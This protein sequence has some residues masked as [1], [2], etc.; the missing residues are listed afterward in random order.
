M[1]SGLRVIGSR[2]NSHWNSLAKEGRSSLPQDIV[3]KKTR[4]EYRELLV[5]WTL[6]EIEQEFDAADIALDEEYHPSISGQRRA[7]V[8]RYYHSIDWHKWSDVRKILTV[9][10]NILVKLE[11]N[12]GGGN[13]FTDADWAE[14]NFVLLKKWIEKDGFKYAD[15]KLVA[16]GKNQAIQDMV[17]NTKSLDVPELHRQLERIHKAIEDDPGLAIG[18]AKELIETTCKTI[19][20]ERHVSFGTSDDLPKLVKETRK[21]LGLV[22]DSIP[23]SA[24]GAEIIRRL[25]SNLGNIAQGLDELRNL[26]GTG[27]GKT[28][29]SK[30][31]SPRH[32]RLAVGAASTLIMFLF[33]THQERNI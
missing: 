12:I 4:N 3:S 2:I 28:G 33:D 27:H 1:I 23:D 26:Y 6:R 11:S 18:T 20:E 5:S 16:I 19:L 14:K 24:K 21:V 32:A 22:P 30:G 7:L 17:D 25:L 8:E 13:P 29:K 15:G 10:E 9:Y 31:L